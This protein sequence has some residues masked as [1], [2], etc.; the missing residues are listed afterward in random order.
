[1]GNMFMFDI[2]KIIFHFVELDS[3]VSFPYWR[4][5]TSCVDIFGMV[6]LWRFWNSGIIEFQ[7]SRAPGYSM[8]LEV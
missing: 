8:R 3:C 1:M 5:S 4:F 6:G 7:N 2:G